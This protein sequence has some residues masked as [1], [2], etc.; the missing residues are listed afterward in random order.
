M[1]SQGKV[2]NIKDLKISLSLNCN[3]KAYNYVYLQK[4]INPGLKYYPGNIVKEVP[5]DDVCTAKAYNTPPKYKRDPEI[6]VDNEQ[7]GHQPLV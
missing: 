2:N 7:I 1:L 4:R 5:V 6:D 3:F